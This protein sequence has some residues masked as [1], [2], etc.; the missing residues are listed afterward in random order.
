ML[1]LIEVETWKNYGKKLEGQY[2]Y[3]AGGRLVQKQ[4]L[5]ELFHD[6]SLILG[7]FYG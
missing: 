5:F 2:P 7:L 1:F 3:L 6:F 4:M